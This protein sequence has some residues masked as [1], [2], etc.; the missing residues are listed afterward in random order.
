MEILT[1]WDKLTE[2]MSK[3]DLNEEIMP[4][5]NGRLVED[6]DSYNKIQK[7]LETPELINAH[8]YLYNLD[9]ENLDEEDVQKVDK[10]YNLG[11]ERGFIQK[12]MEEVPTDVS[13]Q[14]TVINKVNQE[15]IAPVN[16]IS[17]KARIPSWTVLYSAWKDGN[18]KTGE[19]YSNSINPQA[20]KADC[21]AKL[22][23]CGYENINI[24]AIEAGDPDFCGRDQYFEAD[25]NVIENDVLNGRNHNLHV[26]EGE[27]D[28]NPDEVSKD[29]QPDNQDSAKDDKNDSDIMIAK[30]PNDKEDTSKEDTSK[31]DTSKE[32][33]KE[34][35]SKED[36][37]PEENKEDTSK[38]DTSKEDTSKEDTSK[39]ENKELT[40]DEKVIL[41]NDYRKLFKQIMLKC[42]FEDKCF[43]DLTIEEKIKFFTELNK[44]WGKNEPKDF[45]TDKEIEQQNKIII[46]K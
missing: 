25:Q 32:E 7:I 20:A 23:R 30:D 11:I 27:K 33:N 42:Q 14:D 29:S 22:S 10:I 19:C 38:E 40:D 17:Y 12:P 13:A 24:L 15:E 8:K 31:E 6:V 2:A 44:S 46:K 28:K 3:I 45:M 41:K 35:T 1:E 4:V 5:V 43:D 18:V 16:K 34:D 37:S 9:V 36:T 26:D 39:E 21:Y